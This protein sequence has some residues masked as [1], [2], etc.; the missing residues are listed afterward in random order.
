VWALFGGIGAM[1]LTV[2]LPTIWKRLS[3]KGVFMT[4]KELVK[5]NTIISVIKE[6]LS[7]QNIAIQKILLFG[8][9]AKGT[10]RNESDWDFMAVVDKDINIEDKIKLISVIRLR[11]AKQ[12]IDADI[13]IKS[14]K[15]YSEQSKNVGYI[16]YYAAKEG[17]S[18]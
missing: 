2:F 6:E 12:L 15:D 14:V 4:E 9:R 10:A 3:D 7:K 11:L 17:V 8:S 13:I 18:L 16:T 1:S 5:K